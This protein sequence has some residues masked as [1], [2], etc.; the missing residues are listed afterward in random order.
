VRAAGVQELTTEEIIKRYQQRS[1]FRLADY[2]DVALPI[3]T[4]NVHA[5]TMAHRRL[6]PIEEFV[7]R[8]LAMGFSSAA[9][10]SGFLGLEEQVVRSALAGLAQ[11]DSIA[12]TAITGKQSWCL[13]KK[14]RATLDMAELVI[15]EERIFPIHFDAITRKPTLY[16]FEI[17]LKHHEI[18]E[19]GLIEIEQIP[20][21]R[22]QLVEVTPV[23]I[24]R[25]IRFLRPD[26][27]DR[28]DVLAV[29]ALENVKRCYIRA[30]A[31]LFRSREDDN[32]QIAF[33]V[34]GKLSQAHEIAY[35]GSAGF[36]RLLDA[37]SPDPKER[38][39]LASAAA[40]A[41]NESSVGAKDQEIHEQSA[42]AELAAA[43]AAHAL[44]LA[45][46]NE[47]REVLRERLR[48][49]EEE[50]NRLRAE[51]RQLEVRDLYV[52]DHPPLLEDAL[53]NAKERIM[54]IAPWIRAGVVTKDFLSKLEALLSRGVQTY[55]GY[56]IA[57]E[58]KTKARAQDVA[59][60]EELRK[61]KDR[62]SNFHFLRFSNTHAKVL[63]KDHEFYV[64]TSFNWLSYKGD[65]NRGLRDEQGTLCQSRDKVDQKFAELLPRFA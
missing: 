19:E 38:E 57:D 51:A 46:R 43:E 11:T 23:E 27:E 33:V 45:E 4:V 37:I 17:P 39:E 65:P 8:C 6:P 5:L 60:I 64:I 47:D 40:A 42:V 24:E 13:T 16:R 32:S 48:V 61:L 44:Q 36:R 26:V 28:R 62:Y 63:I 9:Q 30:I 58:Q 10:L 56:G 54:I 25:I 50:I 18:T 35:A 49:A 29:R 22:P 55:I 41:G 15:P 1:G 53:M 3:Y 34:E 21:K 12:L 2:A 59:A 52:L 7:L 14:G 20:P 31:L